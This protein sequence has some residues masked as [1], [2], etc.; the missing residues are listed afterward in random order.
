MRALDQLKSLF[1]G[2]FSLIVKQIPNVLTKVQNK[3]EFG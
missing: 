2:V 1:E 3:W